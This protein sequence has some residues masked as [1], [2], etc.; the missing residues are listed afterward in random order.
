MNEAGFRRELLD[1]LRSIQLLFRQD[2]TD[3]EQYTVYQGNHLKGKNI[4]MIRACFQFGP[5]G[6]Q[7]DARIT[8]AAMRTPYSLLVIRSRLA[9]SRLKFS[10]CTISTMPAISSNMAK[11][12]NEVT[13]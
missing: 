3:D 11:T 9:S 2:E 6:K 5:I 12:C 7:P 8:P 10:V 1:G 4:F 13:L